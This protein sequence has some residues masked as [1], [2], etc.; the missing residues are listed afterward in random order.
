MSKINEPLYSEYNI[1]TKKWE[2]IG[3][4]SE[5]C[6]G[7]FGSKLEAREYFRELMMN[8]DKTPSKRKV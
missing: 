1:K 3:M 5:K 6:F 4:Y 8:D 2:L 7:E